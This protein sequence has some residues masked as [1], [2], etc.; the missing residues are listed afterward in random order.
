MSGSFS[1]VVTVSMVVLFSF[2]MYGVALVFAHLKD[3]D[4]S[5]N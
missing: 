1:F 5:E 2:A 4:N 3:R